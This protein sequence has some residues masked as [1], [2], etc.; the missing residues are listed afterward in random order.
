MTVRT[1]VRELTPEDPMAKAL[2]V[3][4]WAAIQNGTEDMTLLVPSLMLGPDKDSAIETG[5]WQVNLKRIGD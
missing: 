5:E 4:I 2:M 3:L 1:D